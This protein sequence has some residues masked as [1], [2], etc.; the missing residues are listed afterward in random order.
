ME[1]VKYLARYIDSASCY[2]KN[3]AIG[4]CPGYRS[5]LKS[6]LTSGS[7]SEEIQIVGLH[8]LVEKESTGYPDILSLWFVSIER[9]LHVP[10]GFRDFIIE[11]II[12]DF[13]GQRKIGYYQFAVVVLLSESDLMNIKQM[14]FIPS[15]Y[16]GKPILDKTVPLMPQDSAEYGNYMVA[17][18]S[19]Q[20]HSEV[21]LFGGIDSPFN[22]L[23]HTYV[24]HNN[25]AYPKCI[26]IYSWNFPCSD[27]TDSIIKSLKEKPYNSV[28]VVVAHTA[29]WKKDSNRE[30][31]KEKFKTKNITVKHIPYHQ[32]AK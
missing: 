13:S 22:H 28:S 30:K 8:T 17:R 5:D 21:K 1:A 6:E 3:T 2:H 31:S 29:F 19:N 10:N 4:L 15:N 25:G 23:W 18:P 26:V 14:S 27:C 32:P 11:R 24:K 9:P 16:W 12:P 20:Y 7:L